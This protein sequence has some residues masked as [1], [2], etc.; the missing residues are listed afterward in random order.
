MALAIKIPLTSR[1]AD[2]TSSQ[3]SSS[4]KGHGLAQNGIPG[5]TAELA[6]KLCQDQGPAQMDPSCVCKP[7][8]E[9]LSPEMQGTTLFSSGQLEKIYEMLLKC[10]DTP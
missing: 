10:P 2:S 3:D 7:R 9:L 8:W 4:F 6:T 5:V 1:N